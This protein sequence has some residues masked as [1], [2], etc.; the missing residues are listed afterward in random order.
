MRQIN[1]FNFSDIDDASDL[2]TSKVK[3]ERELAELTQ[4]L[5]VLPLGGSLVE[6]GALMLEMAALEVELGHKEDAW[7]RAR[8]AFDYYVAAQ[9]WEEAVRACDVLFRADQL[10]SNVALGHGIWLGVTYPIDPD[11]T[12]ALL[13]HL[14]EETPPDSNVAPIAAAAAHYVATLRGQGETGQRLQDYTQQLLTLVAGRQRGVQNQGEFEA[15][16]L[17]QELDDPSRFLPRLGEAVDNLVQGQWWIDRDAL[18]RAL[19]VN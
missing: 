15:W 8:E 2:E 3:F 1:P 10:H 19:P 9:G 5:A 6:R 16:L 4:R 13:Q 18:R 11:W 7:L 17:G 12:V 14:V